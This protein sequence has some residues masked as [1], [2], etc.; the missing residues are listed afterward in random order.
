MEEENQ[1]NI[2]ILLDRV[3]DTINIIS[4]YYSYRKINNNIVMH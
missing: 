2:S 3:L 4:Y 1:Q